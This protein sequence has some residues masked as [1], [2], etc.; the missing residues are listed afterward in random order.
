MTSGKRIS[1]SPH[2]IKNIFVG[3][4][5]QGPRMLAKWQMSRFSS[6]D[7]RLPKHVN[8]YCHPGGNWNPGLGG[9]NRTHMSNEKS[10][11]C[12]GF[13]GDDKL[14]TQLCGDYFI[15]SMGNFRDPY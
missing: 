14:T 8:L 10:P 12:L 15:K 6:W 1:P 4:T 9:V 2:Y 3:S 5:P 13:I 11:G 7:S